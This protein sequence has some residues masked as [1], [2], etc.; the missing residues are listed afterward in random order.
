MLDLNLLITLVSSKVEI[1]T[2]K[3]EWEAYSLVFT[4]GKGNS[5]YKI[6]STNLYHYK[7]N[8]LQYIINNFRI[9][10]NNLTNDQ[11]MCWIGPDKGA[12]HIWQEGQLIVYGICGLQ[13][14]ENKP[15]L[16]ISIR[17]AYR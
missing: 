12:A 8:T 5:C 13:K 4:L 16:E 15:T 9:I 17:Y 11:Q 3:I 1:K 6:Q 2:N 7:N 14:Y 10:C